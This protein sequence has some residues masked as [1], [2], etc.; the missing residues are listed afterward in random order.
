MSKNAN[1]QPASLA[2][3]GIT[4]RLYEKGTGPGGS[5]KLITEAPLASAG[6][7]IALGVSTTRYVVIQDSLDPDGAK[8]IDNW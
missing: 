5:D 1:I 7:F 4:A 6:D 8:S 2:D 3:V